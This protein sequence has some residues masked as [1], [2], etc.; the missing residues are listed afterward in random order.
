MGNQKYDYKE[1][2]QMDFLDNEPFVELK[3]KRLRPVQPEP[4]MLQMMK[5]WQITYLAIMI[6]NSN[7]FKTLL[8][9]CRKE[10][11]LF[12]NWVVIFLLDFNI[13]LKIFMEYFRV[14]FKLGSMFD[15]DFFHLTR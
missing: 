15:V 7:G 4:F 2:I 5:R 3:L 1:I 12:W 10:R 11:F 14:G 9:F 6:K 13:L 8:G